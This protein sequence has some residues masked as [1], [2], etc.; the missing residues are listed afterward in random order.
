[1]ARKP[2]HLIY[3]VDDRPPPG[4]LA[5]LALQHVILMSSTIVLPIVL[6]KEI[7]GSFEDVRSVVALTMMACGAGTI[8]QAIRFGPIGSGYLCPN[9]CGPNFFSACASAAWLGGIP[10]M[11]GM[12]I[13]AGLVEA[14][15]AG[16]I[17]RIRFLFP[18]EITGLV[19][20]M[21][22][23]SLIP[24]GASKFLGL[25]YTG[26]PINSLNVAI[27][28]LTLI[29][30]IGINVWGRGKVRLYSVLTGLSVGY[31]LS[32]C[33]GLVTA[34][35]FNELAIAPWIALPHLAGGWFN[36]TFNWSLLPTFAIVSICGGLKS[37]GNLLMCQTINDADWK[38]PNMKN[39]GRGLMADSICVALCGLIG[40]MASD[41]TSSNVS[42]S[43][44]SGATSR[45][46]GFVAGGAFVVLGFSPKLAALLSIMPMPV[47]GAILLFVTCYM[48]MAGLQIIVSSHPD[49]RKTFI[50]GL[51]LVF[52]LSLAALPQLY[53]GV[54]SWL[55]P[56]FESPLTLATVLAVVLN[57]FLRLGEARAEA[58]K[59]PAA[60]E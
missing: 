45:A 35:Q 23:T 11:R 37:M 51:S 42:L 2:E 25:N 21:V 58:L 31:V 9:I 57:Q 27:A 14:V 55:R 52:G 15:M 13:A 33:T 20:L 40:G 10:L 36:V 26:E 12:T 48:I 30:M 7:G 60:S 19:I 5:L 3:G 53:A 39:L 24:L 49:E 22:G 18:A 34:R 44:A 8:L 6:I 50:I 38:E 32:V 28:S 16:V 54:Y 29:A 46:I 4:P 59:A 17:E 56:L 43:R 41:T 47:M 1:M